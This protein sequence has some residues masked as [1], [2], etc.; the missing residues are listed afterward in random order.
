[1]GLGHI[2]ESHD[3]RD[4]DEYRAR[5]A[6]LVLHP[7]L[8]AAEQTAATLLDD[9][10][11]ARV[12]AWRVNPAPGRLAPRGRPLPGRRGEQYDVAG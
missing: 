1:M 7:F 2:G 12:R 11:G 6:S 4:A 3:Q 8:A 9:L 10:N 5:G